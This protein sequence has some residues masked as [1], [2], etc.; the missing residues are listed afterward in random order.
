MYQVGTALFS[1]HSRK[2]ETESARRES[3]Y[4][5]IIRLGSDLRLVRAF[6]IGE[7]PEPHL[8]EMVRV[9]GISDETPG[10]GTKRARA[11]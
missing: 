8:I 3:S 1:S 7:H 2:N 9:W 5:R 6:V 4:N 11:I 10:S